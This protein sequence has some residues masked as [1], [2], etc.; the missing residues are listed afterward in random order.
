MESARS[1]LQ[2]MWSGLVESGKDFVGTSNVRIE[3]ATYQEISERTKLKLVE[4]SDFLLYSI[5]M[6][7]YHMRYYPF[8]TMTPYSF[9]I[10]SKTS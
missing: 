1:R 10:A 8:E 9:L 7:L 5:R 2:Q 4:T 6:A 3:Y